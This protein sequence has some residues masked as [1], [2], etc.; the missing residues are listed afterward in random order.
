MELIGFVLLVQNLQVQNF[1]C[2]SLLSVN[3]F[4][5]VIC[6]KHQPIVGVRLS[7]NYSRQWNGS[8]REI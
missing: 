6:K 5:T 1:T 4:C 2:P 3:Y 8:V 7:H